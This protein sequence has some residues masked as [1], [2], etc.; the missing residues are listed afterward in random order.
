MAKSIV[1][2]VLFSDGELPG[3]SLG[4]ITVE[5]SKQ[6]ALPSDKKKKLSV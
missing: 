4:Q 2:G 6:N 1:E 3:E 5:I